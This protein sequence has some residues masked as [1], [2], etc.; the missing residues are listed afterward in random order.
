MKKNEQGFSVVEILIVIVVVGLIGAT[1]WFVFSRQNKKQSSK[2]DSQTVQ[3]Q[4]IKKEATN[5]QSTPAEA[6]TE[7]EAEKKFN[8][9]DM[10]GWV[11]L[12]SKDSTTSIKAGG[13][14]TYGHCKTIPGSLLL[15]MVYSNGTREYDCKSL[16]DAVSWNKSGNSNLLL[17]RIAFG[18]YEELWDRGDAKPQ[19]LKLANGDTAERYEYK[20]VIDG[21][22]YDTIE[23]VATHGGGKYTAVMHWKSSTDLNSGSYI[24]QDYFDT[25]VQKT[26]AIK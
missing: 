9:V 12:T 21:E 10:S 8:F 11:N 1:G 2:Q 13:M 26:W 3:T 17:T 16:K 4:E 25:V 19:K 20:N 24:N 5:Q 6:L 22:S 14:H 18:P 15:G 7:K 23:Y